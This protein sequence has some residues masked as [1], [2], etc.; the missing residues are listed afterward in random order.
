MHQCHL[1]PETFAWIT[2]ACNA[3][4]NVNLALKSVQMVFLLV[5]FFFFISH[6][7]KRGMFWRGINKVYIHLYFHRAFATYALCYIVS[8]GCSKDVRYE[9]NAKM[10]TWSLGCMAETMSC[11]LCYYEHSF[12]LDSLFV[13]RCKR[14]RISIRTYTANGLNVSFDVFVPIIF[15]ESMLNDNWCIHTHMQPFEMIIVGVDEFV[16]ATRIERIN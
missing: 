11:A 6:R 1:Y 8:N 14:I 9:M 2:V 5:A 12:D 10:S 4:N 16:S 13:I 7:L 15:L 3:C